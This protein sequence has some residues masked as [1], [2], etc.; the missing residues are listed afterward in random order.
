MGADVGRGIAGIRA[1]IPDDLDPA[2]KSDGQA[3]IVTGQLFNL[4][5]G[6]ELL[7]AGTLLGVKLR[8]V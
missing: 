1:G 8:D 4:L 3:G 6:R 7:A 5:A 2:R